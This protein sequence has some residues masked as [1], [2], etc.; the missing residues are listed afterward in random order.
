MKKR[1]ISLIL[2]A[3]MAVL[4]LSGCAYSYTSDDM[5]QYADFDKDAFVAALKTLVI[6]DADFGTDEEK[7]QEKVLD[8][9]FTTLS[10]Q[11]NAD[12]KMTTGTPNKYSLFYYCYY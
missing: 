11:A 7:R 1:I 3:V 2:V 4:A 5:S 9:I 12:E 10:G 8:A 6:E